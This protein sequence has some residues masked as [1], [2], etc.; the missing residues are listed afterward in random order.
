MS[1][2]YWAGNGSAKAAPVP[3]T[4]DNFIRAESDMYF[5]HTVQ[6]GGFGKFHHFREPAPIDN[7]TV[8]RLNRDTLYSA[9][10]FDLEAGQVTIALPDAGKRFMSMQIFDEDEYVP[11]VVYGAGRRSYTRDTIGTRYMMAGIRTLVNPDDPD[12]VKAVHALQDA[13]KA[14]QKGTGR[15]EIPSWDE[16]SQKKVREALLALGATMPDTRNAFGSRT[17]GLDPV[18]RLVAAAMAWGGNPDK[19]A[20]YLNVVPAGNDGKTVYRLKVPG[21]VPVD[22]F[23]SVIVYDRSGYIPKNDRG[24]YSFNSITAMKDADGGVTI[25]F[26]GDPAQAPNCIPTVPGWNYLVRLYRPRDEVLNG[27]WTFPEAVAV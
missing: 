1:A 26:G 13:I 20:M 19:E 23:W 22:G 24:V 21:S 7:Q 25:Q 17:A 9:A 14:E 27:T 18:R 16:A 15:F 6:E 2:P 4:V 5:G 12:D 8:I 3:V 11:E 10:V